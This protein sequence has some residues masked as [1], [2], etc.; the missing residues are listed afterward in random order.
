MRC[1]FSTTFRIYLPRHEGRPE[2]KEAV[3]SAPVPPGG[4]ETIL[5]VED[6]KGVRET[7]ALFLQGLGYDVLVA[8][9]P[10]DAL[11]QAA[12]RRGAIHLLIT[13]VV[14]P[15]MNGRDLAT[16]LSEMFRELKCLFMSG[17]TANVIA[18]RGI[19]DDGVDFLAKPFTRDDIAR[20]VRR[21]LGSEPSDDR[22]TRSG[23]FIA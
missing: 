19:L 4:D 7:T 9:T 12:E 1:C 8:A 20:K 3:E 17:Y 13:D 5:L 16:K 21:V 10:D 6:E 11:R 14:M 22:S 18:H 15:G 23:S 2:P